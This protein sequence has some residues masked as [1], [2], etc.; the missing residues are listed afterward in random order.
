LRHGLR[1]LQNPVAFELRLRPTIRFEAKWIY[2]S[3]T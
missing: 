1:A 2:S 3:P